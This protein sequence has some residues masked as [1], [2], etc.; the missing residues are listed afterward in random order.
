MIDTV[1]GRIVY[2]VKAGTQTGTQIRFRGKGVPSLRS[3]DI[4]GN[5][6]VTLVVDVPTK[7]SKEAKEALRKFDELS[8][9]SLTAVERA[10]GTDSEPEKKEKEHKEKKKRFWEK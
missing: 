5:H 1:D 6:Y 8:G 9:D 10:S 7:L 4:R 3:R 2:D